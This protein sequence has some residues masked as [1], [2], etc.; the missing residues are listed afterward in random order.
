MSSS[1]HALGYAHWFKSA[2][3]EFESC[4]LGM[5]LFLVTEIMLFCA[6]FIGYGIFNYW[7]PEMYREAHH[8]LDWVMGSVNTV[9]LLA[10]SLTMALGIAYI[11]R[12]ERS[13]ALTMLGITV[14]C[15]AAFMVVKYFE[16]SHKFHL[17]IFPGK[18]FAG[19][20]FESWNAAL[21]FSFYFMMTGLHGLHVLIGMGLIVWVMVR[22]AR[23]EFNSHKFGA[24]E[25]V[26]LYWH[27]VDLIWIFLFPLLYL[28]T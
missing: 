23:G 14:A 21:F 17:G 10:S 25:F 19:E 11:Q 15:G 12:D 18:F 2:E 28:V 20:G 9:V 13:K 26:G 22:M 7:Y 16:Y 4:K 6:L 24:V 5:W 3:H 27:I 8:H 1:D